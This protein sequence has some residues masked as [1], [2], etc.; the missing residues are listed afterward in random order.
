M[1]PLQ[2]GLATMIGGMFVTLTIAIALGGV[3]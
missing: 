2:I 1:T 3:L